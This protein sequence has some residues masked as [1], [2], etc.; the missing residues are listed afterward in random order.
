MS[1]G[2]ERQRMIGGKV[3]SATGLGVLLLVLSCLF[4]ARAESGAT[5]AEKQ[6]TAEKPSGDLATQFYYK[7]E[8]SNFDVVRLEL[9]FDSTGKG[10]F[11]F[12]RK[13]SEEPISAPLE[14]LP[15]TIER[16]NAYLESLRFL[17][18]KETYQGERDAS[19]LG[20]A[21]IGV[22][23]GGHQRQVSF[24]FTRNETMRDLASLFRGISSQEYRVFLISL[25]RSHEPL[26]MDKQLRGL[27]SELKNGWL[28]E[29]EKLLPLLREIQNDEDILLMVR[30]R[31]EKLIQFIKKETG[32]SSEGK[33][34]PSGNIKGS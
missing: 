5:P 10:A 23:R 18:S 4:G 27:E 22:L 33:A 2:I 13:D 30:R 28:G 14:L 26:G 21:T 1:S 24:N 6:T 25:A 11:T 31:A 17:E 16:I 32:S 34:K 3:R 20:T 12:L 8:N 9:K 19:Y 15:T 7:F 29:P